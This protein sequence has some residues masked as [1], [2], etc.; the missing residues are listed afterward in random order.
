MA[1]KNTNNK[2]VMNAKPQFIPLTINPN[3]LMIHPVLIEMAY[4]NRPDENYIKAMD[5][6][7]HYE[8]PV[9]DLNN[10][11]ISHCADV[12]AAQKNG[13]TEIEVYRVALNEQQLR[14]F[15]S[16]KHTYCKENIIATYK[17]IKYYEDYLTKNK[18]GKELAKAL[19]FDTT[20]EKIAALM[21][22]S[23]S[24][25]KRVKEIGDNKPEKLGLINENETCMKHVLNEIK[26]E[27]R[28]NNQKKKQQND[29]LQEIQDFNYNEAPTKP[30]NLISGIF[31][32][33]G[34]GEVELKVSDNKP[35][36]KVN[37]AEIK[38]ILYMPFINREDSESTGSQTFSVSQNKKNGLSIQVTI[39]NF[40]L[41]A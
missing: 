23:D 38:G 11:I 9:I 39:E 8:K 16:L 26:L 35:S 22:T 32:V 14:I 29:D 18:D 12:I 28:A 4:D 37:G 36:M 7:N 33:E 41:A 21:Q 5:I 24:T 13:L 15:I 6:F 25:I 19:P 20:R 31:H 2:T 17:T 40:L 27:R 10:N 3:D 1:T 30:L 34:V